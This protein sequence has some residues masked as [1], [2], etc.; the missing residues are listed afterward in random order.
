MMKKE[1]NSMYKP[2]FDDVMKLDQSLQYLASYEVT[3]GKMIV[4]TSAEAF[5][6]L[7]IKIAQ[8]FN[9]FKKLI[10]TGECNLDF[11]KFQVLYKNGP[12]QQD[13]SDLDISG[14]KFK[15]Q[16]EEWGKDF[17]D[18]KNSFADGDPNLVQK[19]IQTMFPSAN[20]EGVDRKECTNDDETRVKNATNKLATKVS[21]TSRSSR[22]SNKNKKRRK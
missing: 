15:M 5:A 21:K 1:Y 13:R 4:P 7:N 8:K 14:E 20:I 9:Y 3:G 11:I 16:N 6:E 12:Y 10:Q 19:L 2:T 18:P 17:S 22:T